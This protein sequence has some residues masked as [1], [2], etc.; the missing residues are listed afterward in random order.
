M[1]DDPTMLAWIPRRLVSQ[2]KLLK[3]TNLQSPQDYRH[4]TCGITSS[5][6]SPAI[7]HQPNWTPHWGLGAIGAIL[8]AIEG[9]QQVNQCHA[10]WIAYRSNAKR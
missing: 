3:P 9:I 5:P 6:V 4:R 1:S 8:A 10:N 7:V 2:E